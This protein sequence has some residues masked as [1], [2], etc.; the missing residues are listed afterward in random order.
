MA[1]DD[2]ELRFIN[3]KTVINRDGDL[4]VMNRNGEVAV[5][6]TPEPGARDAASP[7]R[8]TSRPPR[9]ALAL[10]AFA[11]GVLVMGAAVTGMHFTVV[12]QTL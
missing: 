10:A 12:P 6:E 8:T 5:I 3:V 1:R 9:A 11:V 7:E 4:V 2:G